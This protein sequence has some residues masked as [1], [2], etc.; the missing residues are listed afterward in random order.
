LSQGLVP[1]NI[2]SPLVVNVDTP[3]AARGGV[4]GARESSFLKLALAAAPALRRAAL[5]VAA[6]I[7]G[8]QFSET[9]DGTSGMP[10]LANLQN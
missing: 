3:V 5:R 7:A 2:L 6:R 10:P 1:T 9:A 4:G 8:R